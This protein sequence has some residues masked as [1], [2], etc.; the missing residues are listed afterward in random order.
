MLDS[1]LSGDIDD[2][3]WVRNLKKLPKL[4]ATIAADVDPDWGVLLSYRPPLCRAGMRP[5]CIAVA[6]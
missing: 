4:Y 5:F 3:E 2:Q 6:Y 1:D